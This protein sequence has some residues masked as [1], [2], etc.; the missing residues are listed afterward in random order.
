MTK[1]KVTKHKN[2]T[3]DGLY[4]RGLTSGPG[5]DTI[6]IVRLKNGSSICYKGSD[7]PIGSWYK[8]DEDKEYLFEGLYPQ[9]E[10][11]CSTCKKDSYQVFFPG[12]CTGCF[13]GTEYGNWE[14]VVLKE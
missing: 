4:L 3:E 14:P 1:I 13:N 12:P 11:S 6:E 8:I 7:K 9:V 5:S 10:K 2:P